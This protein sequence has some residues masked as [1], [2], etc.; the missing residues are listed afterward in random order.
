[1]DHLENYFLFLDCSSNTS[2][3]QKGFHTDGCARKLGKAAS[4]Q[5]LG[6]AVINSLLFIVSLA[7]IYIFINKEPSRSTP[8]AIAFNQLAYQYGQQN[9]TSNST[10]MNP[11]MAYNTNNLVYRGAYF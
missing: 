10:S 4:G 2:N 6:L 1:M 9:G 7:A 8:P 3:G 5:S 11:E